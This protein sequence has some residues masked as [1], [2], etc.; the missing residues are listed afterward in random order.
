[1]RASNREL[2]SRPARELVEPSAGDE[3]IQR[4]LASARWRRGVDR[5][6]APTKLMFAQWL[7]LDAMSRLSAESNQPVSQI[8]V[9]RKLGLGKATLCRM[10]QRLERRGLVDQEPAFGSPAYR[11][12]LSEAGKTAVRQGRLQ[13]EAVSAAWS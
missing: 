11:I 12:I 9:A 7:I 5:A 8:Q 13:I 4:W 6:L 3:G 1:M 10:M 2:A